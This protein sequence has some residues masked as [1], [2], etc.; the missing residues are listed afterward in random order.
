VYAPS[1]R[2]R[3]GSTWWTLPPGLDRPPA[4]RGERGERIPCLRCLGW[5]V[6]ASLANA[7][8]A[9]VGSQQTT[10]PSPCPHAPPLSTS[11]DASPAP[12]AT[13]G[14]AHTTPARSTPATGEYSVPSEARSASRYRGTSLIRKRTPLGPYSRP[15][16]GALGGPRGWAF[17]YERGFCTPVQTR[18][19]TRGRVRNGHDP[20][21][22]RVW[23]YNPV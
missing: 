17:S 2:A 21:R 23:G 3:V 4:N 12:R 1:I 7:L 8:P 10:P 9:P 13:S 20:L 11:S 18:D 5:R 22:E 19:T 14:N 15:L 6:L 16:H